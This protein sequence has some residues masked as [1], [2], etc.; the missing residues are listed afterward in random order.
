MN[1][2][3][4]RGELVRLTALNSDQDLAVMKRWLADAAAWRLLDAADRSLASANGAEADYF[5]ICR[6][7]DERP[8]G[9][10]ALFNIHRA[11]GE[12]WLSIDLGRREHWESGHGADAL[13]LALHRAFC[14][15]ALL[16]LRL[17]VFDYNARAIHS[18]EAAGFAIE[19]RLLQERQ[20]SRPMRAG[21]YMGLRRETFACSNPEN[22]SV[23]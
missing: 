11:I 1:T 4:Y 7:G 10:A 3:H 23:A 22:V 21:V 13:R 12:A 6:L 5:L 14:E 18:Y 8:I 15:M 9:Y 2:R 16:G 20:R 19:G 17:G